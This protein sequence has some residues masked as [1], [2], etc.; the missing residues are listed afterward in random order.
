MTIRVSKVRKGMR[1]GIKHDGKTNF[2]LFDLDRAIAVPE[3]AAEYGGRILHAV[4]GQRLAFVRY[5]TEAF[6]GRTYLVGDRIAS[7]RCVGTVEW[8]R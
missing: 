7:E 4:P 5:L 6:G 2:T 3:I 1:F 8:V